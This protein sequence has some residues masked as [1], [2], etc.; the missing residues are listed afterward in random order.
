[1]LHWDF[2]QEFK[3]DYHNSQSCIF[4]NFVWTTPWWTLRIAWNHYPVWRSTAL[5][6][7]EAFPIKSV[8]LAAG[9]LCQWELSC[10]RALKSCHASLRWMSYFFSSRHIVA[11]HASEVQVLIFHSTEQNLKSWWVDLYSS[12]QIAA[13]FCCAFASGNRHEAS[14]WIIT[15]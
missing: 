2:Q 10:P 4:L 8:S 7:S 3:S 11:Q 12:E 15:V 9:F 14:R 13:E 6:A 5:A 1:M